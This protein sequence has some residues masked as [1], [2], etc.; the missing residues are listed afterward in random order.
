MEYDVLKLS[1]LFKGL[2][3]AEIQAALAA[4]EAKTKNF[5]KDSVIL[6]AGTV[7][8]ELGIV[9]S[10]GVQ[11]EFDDFWGRKS[12]VNYLEAGDVFA[13]AYACAG[14]APMLVN[15]VAAKNSSVLFISAA[16]I[17]AAGADSSP[18]RQKLIKNLLMIMAQRNLQLSRRMLYTS[19]KTIRERL[20]A[21][22]CYLALCSGGNT[23]AVPF[24]RQQLADY[25]HVDRSALSNEISKM[26]KDGLIK[27]N[28]NVFTILQPDN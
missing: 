14:N 13:E 9:L 6:R 22:L 16:Q 26:Q 8:R 25:L 27:V 28:R 10:G 2:T 11:I 7:A 19:Y 18:Y 21:Y 4:L 15:A 24:N 1:A 17:V 3:E 12:I 5:D 20:L 23:A